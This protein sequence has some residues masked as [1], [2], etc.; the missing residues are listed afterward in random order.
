MEFNVLKSVPPTTPWE[1]VLL[2][3]TKHAPIYEVVRK[4]GDE[5]DI[6]EDPMCPLYQ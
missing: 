6:T 4:L 5:L 1:R 3:R 2:T